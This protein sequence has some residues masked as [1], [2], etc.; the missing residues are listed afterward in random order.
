MSDKPQ[1]TATLFDQ[2]RQDPAQHHKLIEAVR[3]GIE[4][5]L[6]TYAAEYLGYVDDKRAAFDLLVQIAKHPWGFVREGAIMGLGNLGLP[7]CKDVLEDIAKNDSS[8]VIRE[9]AGAYLED[10]FVAEGWEDK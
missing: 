3:D 9:T 1:Y 5:V 10:F 8:E 6:L 4:P 2:W 7:Q